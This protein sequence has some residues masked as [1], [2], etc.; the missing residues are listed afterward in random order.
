MTLAESIAAKNSATEPSAKPV[1]GFVNS[2]LKLGP[3]KSV[4]D[5]VNSQF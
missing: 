5:K 3:L 1:E 2:K 4:V